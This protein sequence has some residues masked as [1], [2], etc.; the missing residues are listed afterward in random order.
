M[1][2]LLTIGAIARQLGVARSRLD[3]A[4]Q[5]VGLQERGRAGILRLFSLDQIPSMRAALETVRPHKRQDAA[6]KGG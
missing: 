4:V 1:A 2:E 5:K 3:Y 6:T